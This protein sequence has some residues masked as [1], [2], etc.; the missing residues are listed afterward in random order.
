MA[1]MKYFI[2]A[3]KPDMK[4]LKNNLLLLLKFIVEREGIKGILRKGCNL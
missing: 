3:I 2:L 4:I 1:I